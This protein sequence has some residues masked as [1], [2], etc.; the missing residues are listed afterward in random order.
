VNKA[1]TDEHF[2]EEEPLGE[3]KEANWPM[4]DM[5][6]MHLLSGKKKAGTKDPRQCPVD[7][8]WWDCCFLFPHFVW[9]G[10]IKLK[11]WSISWKNTMEID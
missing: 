5:K 2:E 4:F 1:K 7:M 8:G 3:E 6:R 9:Y 10:F 11:S